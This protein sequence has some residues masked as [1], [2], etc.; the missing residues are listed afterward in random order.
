MNCGAKFGGLGPL[1]VR[2]SHEMPV[3]ECVGGGLVLVGPC[4]VARLPW[5]RPAIAVVRKPFTNCA[6]LWLSSR[7]ALGRRRDGQLCH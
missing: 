5:G 6:L 1:T 2:G 3:F 4:L 7:Y